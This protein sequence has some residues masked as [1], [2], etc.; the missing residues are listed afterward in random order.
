[1]FTSIAQSVLDMFPDCI[2]QYGLL[3]CGMATLVACSF[4][5]MLYRAFTI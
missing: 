4:G 1:M 5:I 2:S 3:G